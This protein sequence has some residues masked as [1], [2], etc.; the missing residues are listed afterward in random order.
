[1]IEQNCTT[2]IEL[3]TDRLQDVPLMILELPSDRLSEKASPEKWSGKE[4]LGHL[5]DSARA[6]LTRFLEAQ[7]GEEPYVSRSYPQEALVNLNGYQDLTVS[8]VLALWE[9]WNRE[10]VRV[11]K[12][13]PQG[14]LGRR[15]SFENNDPEKTLGWLI[16][17]YIEHLDHHLAVI[18]SQGD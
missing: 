9:A 2:A 14:A 18:K 17:D 12:L 1:M 15:I 4:I 5:T 3:L 8:Q 7:H 11:L 10:I 6:N 16:E 13:I